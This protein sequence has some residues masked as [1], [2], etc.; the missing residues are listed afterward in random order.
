[1]K[2][3]KILMTFS[4][5]GSLAYSTLSFAESFV[6]NDIQFEGLKRVKPGA[7]LLKIPVQTGS[8]ID[9][10]ELGSIIKSLYETGNFDNI[11]ASHRDGALIFTFEERPTIS[12]I[13][14]EGNKSIKDDM[15]KS[16]LEDSG[17]KVGEALDRTRLTQIEHEL[18]EFYYSIGKYNAKIK[19]EITPLSDNRVDLNLNIKEGPT[20]EVEQINIIGAK[21]IPSSKLIAK[22]SLRDSVPWWDF[23]GD[24]KYQKQKL[25]ADLEVLKSYYMDRGYANF[26]I[27][28]TQVNLTPDKKGIYVTIN[29][30]EGGKYTISG[31]EIRGKVGDN[32]PA[33]QKIIDDEI[34]DGTLYNGSEITKIE[35]K[36]K[37][38]LSNNG[39][40]FP[41]VK[42]QSDFNEDEKSVKLLIYIDAGPRVYVRQI[43]I[44]GN[45][46]TDDQVIRRELRQME[47][48]LLNNELVER[49]KTRLNRAGYFNTVETEITPV[50]NVDDQVDVSYRISERNTGTIRGGVGYGT[51]S[52]V[53]FNAGITED[54]WLGTGNNVALNLNTTSSD[55]V[56]SLSITDPYF[57]VNGVSLSGSVFY[58]TYNADKTLNT[59]I[60]QY[61]SR[62]V[63]VSNSLGFPISET[64]SLKFG[65][66]FANRQLS[67]M[68]PQ[69]GM[70]RYLE[71][72]GYHPETTSSSFHVNDLLL[73]AYWSY[74]TL[75]R[76]FFPKDGVK[77]SMSGKITTPLFENRF[78]KL[79]G[80]AAYYHSLDQDKDWVFLTRARLGYGDGYNGRDLPFY[81]N[82]YAGGS[83]LLRGFSPS[84]VS[85]KAI[86]FGT[87]CNM[88]DSSGCTLSGDSIGGNAMAVVSGELIV[89]TPFAS[90][91]YKNNLRTSVF[92]DA[93]TVWDTGWDF[94]DSDLADYSKPSDIRVSRGVALQW[95]SPLGPLIFSYAKPIKK[96]KGDSSQEFQF[97]IG[98]T[99]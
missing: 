2:F 42:T 77:L 56:A 79:V 17:V 78:Y 26:K 1:M 50:P 28:S 36:I 86:Y 80:D 9:E 69:Y 48:Y 20:A 5:L 61:S 66:E 19:A 57:T 70:W 22:L 12:K 73:S 85:P 10:S 39:Y 90:E 16:S 14:F 94:G 65:W 75:D 89:P 4:L 62:A 92:I 24:R 81:E 25:T 27:T 47:G 58:N 52:G 15:L 99:W 3:N 87:N 68:T 97:N 54:N 84:S 18:E 44:E 60:S 41:R 21:D 30:D 32:K 98:T 63:G 95:M 71:S 88:N 49:G 74:N 33:I 34:K 64:N 82:F 96:Y 29:I 13:T 51:D 59:D 31:A 46:I 72:V 11:V 76:G 53:T 23:L 7:V 37:N 93:G 6:V 38:L 91:Q 8:K 83:Y 45:N 43:N 40:A 55:K 35:D 67:D